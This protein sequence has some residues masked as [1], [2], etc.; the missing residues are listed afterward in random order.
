MTPD[1][2]TALR[3]SG[4]I[5]MMPLRG[6]AAAVESNP[7]ISVLPRAP[8]G[9]RKMY[10]IG[11]TVRHTPAYVFVQR[12]AI[13]TATGSSFSP[14]R[15]GMAR[16]RSIDNHCDASANPLSERGAAKRRGVSHHRGLFVG[17]KES[18]TVRVVLSFNFPLTSRNF[19]LTPP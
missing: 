13:G 8:K 4:V 17:V 5:E 18:Q 2:Q 10:G 3:L 14:L 19:P 16:Q 1:P 9:R 6:I 11:L 12:F 7:I 15:E